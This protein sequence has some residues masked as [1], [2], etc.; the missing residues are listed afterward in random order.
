LL[1]GMQTGVAAMEPLWCFL[2][3][4]NRTSTWPRKSGG[5]NSNWSWST[6]LHR[7]TIHSRWKVETETTHCPSVHK[8]TVNTYNGI[9]GLK[10]EC[11]SYI[12]YSTVEPRRQY[13]RWNK[14]DTKGHIYVPLV[15]DI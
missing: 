4:L 3:E 13:A 5:R 1:V 6:A 9:S 15:C 14:P 11:S 7:S 12:C 10:K 8:G 2:K